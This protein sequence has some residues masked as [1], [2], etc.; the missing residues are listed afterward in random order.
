MGQSCSANSPASDEEFASTKKR[1]SLRDIKMARSRSQ[2][3][4]LNNFK[5]P[6]AQPLNII[7]MAPEPDNNRDDDEGDQM[8]G[9]Q[10]ESQLSDPRPKRLR[11]RPSETERV[12]EEIKEDDENDIHAYTAASPSIY[13]LAKN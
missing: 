13:D 2:R 9:V 3:L 1:Y 11:R 8:E 7:E 5:P 10:F 4:K 6:T 12:I